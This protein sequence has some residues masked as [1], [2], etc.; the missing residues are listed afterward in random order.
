[1]NNALGPVSEAIVSLHS[2]F[3]VERI[4]CRN[5]ERLRRR[6]DEAVDSARA[7]LPVSEH[8]GFDLRIGVVRAEL[9]CDRAD[10]RAAHAHAGAAGRRVA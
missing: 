8:A 4:W 10:A 9:F 6:F 7:S 5:A 1:M 3:I 2:R